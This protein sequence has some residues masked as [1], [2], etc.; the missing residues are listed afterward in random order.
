MIARSRCSLAL[1]AL[2][3]ACGHAKPAPATPPKVDTAALAAELDAQQA[4]LA[5]VLHRDR[6]ECAA[7]AANLKALFARMSATMTRAREATKD[8]AVAKALTTDLKRYDAA[9]AQRGA[10]MDADVTP[11]AP[12]IHDQAVRD[13]LVTM[14][15]L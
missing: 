15:T 10:Q 1:L 11:D 7:L 2:L 4:E 12:C 6:A 14:P 8:P 9:A 13:T 3:V 5:L